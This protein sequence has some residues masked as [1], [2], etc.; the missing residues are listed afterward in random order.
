MVEVHWSVSL[1]RKKISAGYK[2]DYPNSYFYL[3][4]EW[5]QTHYMEPSLSPCE[6]GTIITPVYR[7]TLGVECV[8]TP[9]A[10]HRPLAG[11][12]QGED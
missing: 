5:C 10:S 9:F 3:S 11:K 2:F 7:R 12:W 6:G 4:P 1:G 8:R